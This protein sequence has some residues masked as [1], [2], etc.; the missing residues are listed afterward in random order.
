[1]ANVAGSL[2]TIAIKSRLFAVAGDVDAKFNLGGRENEIQTNGDNTVCVV[3]TVMASDIGGLKLR[4]DDK[5]RD[6]EFLTSVRDSGDL[7]PVVVTKASGLTYSG[8][9]QIIGKI[10]TSTK[11]QTAEIQLSGEPLKLEQQ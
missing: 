2:K 1:M 8:K 7:V 9:M 11:D 5:R 10:E 6:Q 4:I 3:Q